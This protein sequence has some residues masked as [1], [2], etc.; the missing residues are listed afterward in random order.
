MIF[1]CIEPQ[2]A[3]WGSIFTPGKEYKF[4]FTK[5]KYSLI[6]NEERYFYYIDI[7]AKSI[8]YV[9]EGYT[10]DKLLKSVIPDYLS[11]KEINDKYVIE[12]ELDCISTISDDN[13]NYIFILPNK[14]ELKKR[15]NTDDIEYTHY[16]A[17]D[18]FDIGSYVREEKFKKLMG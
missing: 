18:Y 10:S 17:E 4:K 9:N 13:H 14:S 16:F 11:Y 2:F 7:V 5:N 6:T 15:Y 1:K 8:H 12:V 3:H